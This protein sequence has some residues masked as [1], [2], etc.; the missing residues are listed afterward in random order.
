MTEAEREAEVVAF[1][2]RLEQ[3]LMVGAF[4]QVLAAKSSMP[5][6][7]FSFFMDSIVET[8][9]DSVAEC[10]EVAYAGLSLQAASK[11]LMLESRDDLVAFIETCRPSWVVEGDKISFET[12]VET[13]AAALSATRLI[14]ESLSYASELER[15]V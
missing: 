2:I 10:A 5:L 1:P 9:R 7:T 8:V 14:T 13:K 11:L 6:A 15:I 12:K 4:N 3:Y